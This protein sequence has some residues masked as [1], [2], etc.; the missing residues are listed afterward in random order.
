MSV[1]RV[2][3]KNPAGADLSQG[4][5]SLRS[6]ADTVPHLAPRSR[7]VKAFTIHGFENFE[8][9]AYPGYNLKPIMICCDDDTAAKDATGELVA[10]LD[11]EPLDV[12]GLEQALHL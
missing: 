10:R 3:C 7:V 8:N 5:N 2:D 4:L 11:W 9:S 6:G 1:L 12:G